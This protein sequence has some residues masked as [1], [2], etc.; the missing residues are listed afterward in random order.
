MNES[1]S[2]CNLFMAWMAGNVP[3]PT[4]ISLKRSLST[5]APSATLACESEISVGKWVVA[6]PKH[7]WGGRSKLPETFVT[8]PPESA[9]PGASRS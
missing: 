9:L 6:W 1:S 2:N 4:Y 3:L 7:H 5:L 8:C